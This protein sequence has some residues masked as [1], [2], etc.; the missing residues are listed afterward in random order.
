MK[1]RD[2]TF[3]PRYTAATDLNSFFSSLCEEELISLHS[4]EYEKLYR[5]AF[6]G[7]SV[8]IKQELSE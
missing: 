2:T 4:R 6:E 3:G 5:F 7:K 1:Q 8:L